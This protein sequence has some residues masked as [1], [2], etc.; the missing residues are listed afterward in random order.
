M[1]T[2]AQAGPHGRLAHCGTESPRKR[3]YAEDAHGEFRAFLPNGLL[4][5]HFWEKEIPFVEADSYH[6]KIPKSH[7]H[8]CADLWLEHLGCLTSRKGDN[9]E[10][11]I[12]LCPRATG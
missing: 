6:F 7:L 11:M 12:N 2:S 9:A 1:K 4:F 3:A 8:T 10:S 5:S